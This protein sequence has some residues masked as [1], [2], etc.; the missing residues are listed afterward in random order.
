MIMIMIRAMT[1]VTIMSG[2]ER[3]EKRQLFTAAAVEWR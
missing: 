2:T 3:A 1:T